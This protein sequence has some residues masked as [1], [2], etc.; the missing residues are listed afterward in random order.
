MK[1]GFA[2][3]AAQTV[4]SGP[5]SCARGLGRRLRVGHQVIQDLLDRRPPQD[6]RDDLE[7]AGATVRAVLPADV[8]HALEQPRPADAVRPGSDG[9]DLA[10]AGGG[11]NARRFAFGASTPW[12]RIRC[13][14]GRGTGDCRT[15]CSGGRPRSPGPTQRPALAEAGSRSG[16]ARDH[17]GG[18]LAGTIR[19]Q[20]GR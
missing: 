8:E 15:C 5:G 9:L 12:Y 20:L 18:S 13:S 16:Y 6:G 1:S 19:S 4:K 14:L 2:T 3:A 10:R 7:L 11:G 17:P